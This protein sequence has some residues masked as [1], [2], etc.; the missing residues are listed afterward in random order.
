[1]SPART[2]SL[3]LDPSL[4][5]RAQTLFPDS[6]QRDLLLSTDNS[7]LLCCSRQAGKSTTVA[8]LALHTA[9]F[10]VPALVLILSPTLRQSGEFFRKV[11]DAYNARGRP[12]GAVIENSS[13]L[14]LGNGS[15]IVCL[16]GKEGTVR[17]F[18]AVDLLILDEAARVA[19]DDVLPN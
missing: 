15:R 14:E 19:A 4:I 7:V 13:T 12:S 3:M 8:A 9:L 11:K 1:M 10:R 2:L 18:S 6:W 5:L 16:P 17:S